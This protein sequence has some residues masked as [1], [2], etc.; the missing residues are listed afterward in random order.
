MLSKSTSVADQRVS[1]GIFTRHQLRNLQLRQVSQTQIL[2]YAALDWSNRLINGIGSERQADYNAIRTVTCR[3]GH[4]FV[5]GCGD[6]L[7][8]WPILALKEGDESLENLAWN[9]SDLSIRRSKLLVSRLLR[10]SVHVR[11]ISAWLDKHDLYSQLGQLIAIAITHCLY[12]VLRGSIEPEERQRYSAKDRSH[13][14][15][16]ASTLR[17]EHRQ[18]RAKDTLDAEDINLKQLAYLLGRE[19]LRDARGR[20]ACVVNH[21][22]ELVVRFLEKLRNGA[23]DATLISDIELENL[24]I[25]FSELVSDLLLSTVIGTKTCEYLVSRVL[26][27]FCSQTAEATRCA[28]N[29]NCL[30]HLFSSFWISTNLAD[31]LL[32]KA[33]YGLRRNGENAK[34]GANSA[35]VQSCCSISA[36]HSI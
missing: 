21:D 9:L 31:E 13:I 35:R 18:R 15:H 12:C 4:N 25:F 34:F 23:V 8:I 14:D 2:D 10:G 28:C 33:Q 5:N 19:R 6:V 24:Y 17:S 26:K 36:T 1:A 11:R 7:W 3:R 27:G 30:S 20:H 16:E 32:I 22:I 29:Q